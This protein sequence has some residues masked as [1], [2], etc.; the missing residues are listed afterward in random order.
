MSHAP[1]FLDTFAHLLWSITFLDFPLVTVQRS[2][3]T[4]GRLAIQFLHHQSLMTNGPL[5]RAS[6]GRHVHWQR[7]TAF[8]ILVPLLSHSPE[9]AGP[10]LCSST[11]RLAAFFTTS[12]IH[13]SWF[14]LSWCICH[15]GPPT[16]ARFTSVTGG[17]RPLDMMTA[18][19]KFLQCLTGCA[20]AMKPG[21]EPML[22]RQHDIACALVF[23]PQ[24]AQCML[25]PDDPRYLFDLA[26]LAKNHKKSS[27]GM[28][29]HD[30]PMYAMVK[31]PSL[32]A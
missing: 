14:F 19:K 11:P 29:W 5:P 2:Q 6:R 24:N 27:F 32:P 20:S 23:F 30:E 16:N 3:H 9:H 31:A 25:V 8:S 4:S 17:P 15:F 10:T 12:L 13:A 26:F 28:S 21:H 18:Y 7:E 22:H 1:Q